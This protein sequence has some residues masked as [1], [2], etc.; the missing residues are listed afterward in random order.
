MLKAPMFAVKRMAVHD[1]PGIRTTLFL[2][3][4]PLRCVWCHN[5]EGQE[6]CVEIAYHP[7]RC[8]GCGACMQQECGAHT[9]ASK[10]Q[11]LFHRE[12]CWGCGSCVE[13]CPTGALVRYGVMITVE[14]AVSLLLEDRA[15]YGERGGITLS[16]GECLLY[17][18]FCQSLLSVMKQKGIGTA[19]DTCGAVPWE[20][21]EAVRPY[22]DLFLYDVKALDPQVQRNC[23]GRIDPR[24]Q[25]NLERLC[26][27]GAAVEVRIPFV[28]DYNDGELKDIAAYL[29]T[30][31]RLAGVRILP[32]HNFSD[33]KYRALGRPSTMPPRTPT[34]REVEAAQELLLRAGL[35]LIK[36]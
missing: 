33:T 11:H 10:G 5:P 9:V 22:T 18:Q 26:A 34:E 15:F 6:A 16:G 1:G 20:S 23:M 35:P 13:A 2:K 32:Y 14:E 3:G 12:R 29:K 27:L 21:V 30:L 24:I 7:E 28:P 36:G 4:C 25:E 19:V 17:P 31:P 8:V